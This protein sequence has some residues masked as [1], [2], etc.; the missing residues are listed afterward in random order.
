[1][2]AAGSSAFTDNKSL[3]MVFLNGGVDSLGL[4]VPTGASQYAAYKNLRQHL[5]FGQSDLINL[6]TSNYATPNCCQSMVNL[7]NAEKLSWISNI[8]PLRQPTTKQMIVNN[9]RVMPY[10]VGSHNSQQIMWQS[11]SVDPSA[12][13][14]WGGK[15]LDLISEQAGLVSP[16]ISLDGTQLFT[17]TLATPTF[18]INPEIIQNIAGLDPQN[19]GPNLDLFYAMQSLQRPNALDN[20]VA[21]R[22][23]RTV[24]SSSFLSTVMRHIGGEAVIYP[25]VTSPRDVEFQHQLKMAARLVEAAPALGHPRQVIMVQMN[26]F[27]TH[28]NQDFSLPDLLRS[29]FENL[30]AFQSDLESRGLDHRVV[31]FSQSDFGRTPSINA[32]GTDHGWGGHSFL[33]GTPVRGGQIVGEVPDFDVETEKMFLHLLI[34]DFSVEQYASNLARWFGLSSSEI[35]E[36]LPNLSRF[37]DIDFELLST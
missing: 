14:G 4:L 37:N 25:N 12:R 32:N 18:S 9:E 24:E 31:T 11:G 35:S 28:D 22:N 21:Y 2:G 36:V 6:G 10:F 17:S 16:N 30:E 15:M 5:A 13:E 27:D 8:G 23:R 34:P 29:L 1:M 33:M 20:E 19:P 3:V 7:F 26:G